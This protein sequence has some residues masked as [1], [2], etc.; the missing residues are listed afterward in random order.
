MSNIYASNGHVLGMFFTC[1]KVHWLRQ[2]SI[3][4]TS[5]NVFLESLHH[6]DDYLVNHYRNCSILHLTRIHQCWKC[7]SQGGRL[8]SHYSF[9]SI[10]QSDASCVLR[11]HAWAWSFAFVSRIYH[12][13]Y[14][15]LWI[16]NPS[17]LH[18]HLHCGQW[19]KRFRPKW[20][21]VWYVLWPVRSRRP[22]RVLHHQKDWLG[23]MFK[24]GK[25]KD[26]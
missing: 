16:R 4:E 10:L 24:I 7:P 6:A 2:S 15:L 14:R 5:G 3:G 17:W 13:S 1:W 12:L 26:R 20:T 22:L 19:W 9:R 18:L 23:R 8:P 21:L 11:Y 25:R